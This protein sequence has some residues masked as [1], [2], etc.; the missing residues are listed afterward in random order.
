MNVQ[1]NM[2]PIKPTSPIEM[3]SNE[4]YLDEPED[5][6]YNRTII[7]LIKKFKEVK[8]DTNKHFIKLKDDK[9]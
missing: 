2:S 7:N 3:F 6:E 9:K 8:K 5:T 1:D 4:N